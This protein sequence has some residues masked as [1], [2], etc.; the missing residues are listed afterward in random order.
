MP[1]LDVSTYVPQLF[2]LFVTF[3]VLYLLMRRIALPKVGAAIEARRNRL[4]G[5]LARAA[6]LKSQAEAV[7]AEYERTLAAART[8]AQATMRETADRLAAEAA[9]RQRALAATLADQVEAAERRIAAAKQHALAEVR[10]I[11][12][13][14]AG[15]VT[16]KLI[17]AAPQPAQL[18][19]AVDRIMTERDS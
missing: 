11:A 16:Q 2:W 19:A 12:V 9:E 5:D 7:L 15:S 4:E 18:T 13:E 6:E 17:G 14:V 10:G 8:D 3:L 1:Q